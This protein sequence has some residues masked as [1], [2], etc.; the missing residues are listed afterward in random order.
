MICK[1]RKG[2]R[3]GRASPG[4]L[5]SNPQC[6]AR[7]GVFT[8]KTQ[9]TVLAH[10]VFWC[11]GILGWRPERRG[12]GASARCVFGTWHVARG[13]LDFWPKNV[14]GCVRECQV[15]AGRTL[16]WQPPT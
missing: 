8:Q 7:D 6:V 15:P 14:G 11:S 10:V 9:N 2:K 5:P 3:S 4:V 13:G 12:S 1:T 16:L